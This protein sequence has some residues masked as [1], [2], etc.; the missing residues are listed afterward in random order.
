[1]IKIITDNRKVLL[2]FA[3]AGLIGGCF[4]GVCQLDS[5]P[6]DIQYEKPVLTN[7]HKHDRIIIGKF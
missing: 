4:V 3:I 7:P 2:F 5:F 1:M 6:E